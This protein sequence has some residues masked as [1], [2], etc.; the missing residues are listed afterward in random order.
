MLGAWKI[1]FFFFLSEKPVPF[2][3]T[4]TSERAGGIK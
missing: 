4:T 1:F 2:K 3:Y